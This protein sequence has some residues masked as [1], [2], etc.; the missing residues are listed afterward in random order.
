MGHVAGCVAVAQ[1]AVAAGAA[2]TVVGFGGH[3][4]TS[5][6]LFSRN[7]FVD[8]KRNVGDIFSGFCDGVENVGAANSIVFLAISRSSL[9]KIHSNAAIVLFAR[10]TLVSSMSENGPTMACASSSETKRERNT[11]LTLVEAHFAFYSS[12]KHKDDRHLPLRLLEIEPLDDIPLSA[13]HSEELIQDMSISY[14]LGLLQ[15]LRDI[16]RS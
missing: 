4:L 13:R 16:R 10:S 7:G 14:R 5:L 1:L 9:T 12:G 15:L 8:G 2:E 3:R 6:F 11:F